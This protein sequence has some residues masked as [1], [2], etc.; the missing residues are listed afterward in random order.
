MH[1]VLYLFVRLW[2]TGA[3]GDVVEAVG[4]GEVRDVLGSKLRPIVAAD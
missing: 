3:A 4:P 1:H 2:E